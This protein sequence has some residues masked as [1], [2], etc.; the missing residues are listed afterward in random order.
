MSKMSEKINVSCTYSANAFFST[1]CAICINFEN[2]NIEKHNNIHKDGIH[3]DK[4]D[5]HS[6]D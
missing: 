1:N 3:S 6:D 5:I 4:D 2:K